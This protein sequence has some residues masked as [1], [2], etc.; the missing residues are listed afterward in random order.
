[1]GCDKQGTWVKLKRLNGLGIECRLT[2]HFAKQTLVCWHNF[3]E[4]A[5]V[6]CIVDRSLS[7]SCAIQIS[8]GANFRSSKKA[9]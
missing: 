1:M 8:P 2:R 9:V 3:Q 7:S 4:Q 6:V 5:A